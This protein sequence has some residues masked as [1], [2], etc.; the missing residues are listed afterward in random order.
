MIGLVLAHC[1]LRAGDL[2]ALQSLS[3]AAGGS[4]VL[5]DLAFSLAHFD[6][7]WRR[8]DQTDF[9]TE[10]GYPRVENGEWKTRGAMKLSDSSSLL[11]EETISEGRDGAIHVRYDV[12]KL[13]DIPTQVLCVTT[14]LPIEASAGREIKVNGSPQVLPNDFENTVLFTGVARDLALPG[15]SGEISVNGGRYAYIQDDRRWGGEAF[16]IRIPLVH[17]GDDS[18]YSIELTLREIPYESWPVSIKEKVNRGWKDPVAADGKGGWTDQGPLNDMSVLPSGP[19]KLHGINFDLLPQASQ[20]ERTCLVL[21]GRESGNDGFL[22]EVAIPVEGRSPAA[23]YLLHAS[24][25]LPDGNGQVGSLEAVFADGTVEEF[26]ILANRDVGDWWGPV[27]LSNGAVGWTGLNQ[28]SNVG[29]YISRFDLPG[30]PLREIRLKGSGRALWMVAGLSVSNDRIQL[31]SNQPT[32]VKAGGEW[33]PFA[34]RLDID[35]GSVFDF[36]FLNEGPAGQWGFLKVSPAGR[37]EFEKKP[38]ELV[39]FWGANLCF[40]ANFPSHDLADRVADRLA[41][42]G[43]NVVRLHHYDA[44]LV[45]PGGRSYEFDPERLDRM[46][47]LIAALKKRGIYISIDL[48]SMRKFRVDEIPDLGRDFDH[49][50]KQLIPLSEKAFDSWKRF[51]QALLQHVNPYTGLS[52]ADD[53]VLVGICPVNEDSPLELPRGDEPLAQ[54]YRQAFEKWKDGQPA[55]VVAAHPAAELRFLMDLHLRTDDRLRATLRD[56]GAKAPITGANFHELEMLTL[57][58]ERYDY[59]DTHMYWDHPLFVGALWKL[60]FRFNQTSAVRYESSLPRLLMPTRVLGRPFTVTEFN[61]VMPNMYRAEGALLA[62]SYASLQGWD[63]MFNF[64]YASSDVRL[65][66]I[67]IGSIFDLSTDP[68]GMLADRFSALVFR[69]GDVR[70]AT[71][72]I[73]FVPGADRM[74][75]VE[76][77]RPR[78]FPREFSRLGLVAKIGVLPTV[79]GDALSVR[80]RVFD[81]PALLKEKGGDSDYLVDGSLVARLIRDGVLPAGSLTDKSGSALIKSETGEIELDPSRGMFALATPRSAGFVL[82]GGE[83]GRGDF[84][85][86]RNGPAFGVFCVASVDGKALV[87][88][89]RILLLHLTDVLNKGMKFQDSNRR[90]LAELGEMPHLAHRASATVELALPAGTWRAWSVRTDGSRVKEISLGEKDG[91]RV[92]DLSTGRGDGAGFS[93]EITREDEAGS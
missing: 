8:V 52:L 86:V 48:Y 38:G 46:E 93:Y 67:G 65:D 7:T 28:S 81:D 40:E 10:Q 34:H 6:S 14:S 37:F 30:K 89:R 69:R 32:V 13:G 36:S 80:A 49:E 23:L 31:P 90:L 70:P 74:F 12:E 56:L 41:R 61:F 4:F 1:S 59:V 35:K 58:R 63:A 19:L 68:I 47:Y 76:G 85:S 66:T 84:L 11:V 50:I 83:V 33:V 57:A 18:R 24:A 27:P 91:R 92:L 21:T 5:G 29:L 64:D 16:Q 53:P 60:P 42:S 51:A 71:T 43:Y 45:R 62:P 22:R 88:S 73:G 44:G 25:W 20:D 26:P 54:L 75:G 72:V 55:E 2:G 77:T 3:P 82:P 15:A 87:E 39:R 78:D 17:E 79:G 9:K